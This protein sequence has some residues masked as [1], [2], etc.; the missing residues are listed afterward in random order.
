L[1]AANLTGTVADAR[2]PNPLPAIDGSNLTGVAPTKA[3]IEALGIGLPAANL[4]GNVDI[5]RLPA[6]VLNSNVPATD[7]SQLE[8]NQA[9]LAFKIASSNQLSK[10][11]M[12]DQMIDEYQ[13]ATGID[14][15]A[16]TNEYIG[17]L[18]TG[19][20]MGGGVS[21]T[22]STSS[23]GSVTSAGTVDG[24]YT[25]YQWNSGSAGTYTTNYAQDYEYLV[26]GG[27]GG[28]GGDNGGGGGAGG[29]RTATG[30]SVPSGTVTGITV[31][32]AGSRGSGHGYAGMGGNS[33]FSTIT[34]LGGGYGIAGSGTQNAAV[35]GSGGGGTQN[36][37]GAAGTSGQGNAGGSSNATDSG[38]AGGGGAG[39]VGENTTASTGA[40]SVGDGGDGLTS[41]IT[42]T[43]VTRGGGGGGGANQSSG[44][45]YGSGG[46]GGGGDGDPGGGGGN[47]SFQ[48]G[49][50]NTGGGGGGGGQSA[51]A[52]GGDGGTGIVIIRRP[53]IHIIPGDNLTLQSTATTAESAPTT[54]DLV[55]LIED[56]AGTATVNTDIKGFVS[57]NG[58]AFSSA[59]TF[60]DEGDWGTNKRILV[61]RN[62]DISGITTGTAMK[63]K[64]T[65]HN[66]SA[67][68]KET[69]IH[70]TS[71][72]WA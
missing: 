38:G 72:A 65:T 43:A 14:A 45:D 9:I 26:I 50:A 59:V 20:F 6:G 37:P 27:G 57:R 22:P 16:S 68:S 19:K 13:D 3:T 54:A 31:G 5:A 67:S 40:N 28:G 60:V 42:G 1:P 29:Y 47:Q 62:I 15:G 70:A 53:T 17:G 35:G 2:L 69:R 61:A 32:A 30:F 33:V 64:L 24:D 21:V 23:T 12:V 52:S 41:S 4:T 63:Y 34:S 39:A 25:Y 71:L 7:T 46:S 36:R 55:V 66:Q 11:S 48:N 51:S 8:M 56:G 49:I 18:G 10:F 58:S 44:S